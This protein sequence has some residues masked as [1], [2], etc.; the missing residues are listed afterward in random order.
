[1]SNFLSE[2]LC[3]S[4]GMTATPEVPGPEIDTADIVI[5]KGD[6]RPFPTYPENADQALA[7]Y[8]IM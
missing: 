2:M 3:K 7:R 8:I 6:D 5:K 1:M 4:C